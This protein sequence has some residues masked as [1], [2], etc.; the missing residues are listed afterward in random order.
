[1][2]SIKL[3]TIWA[4]QKWINQTKKNKEI[5]YPKISVVTPVY[6]WGNYIKR[7]IKSIQNQNFQQIEIILI[8]DCS[9]DDAFFC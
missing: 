3:K 1:M 2:N 5:N 8:D 6:N 4:L 9:Q 7:F